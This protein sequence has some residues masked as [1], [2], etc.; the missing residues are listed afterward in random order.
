[1]QKDL[2]HYW[3]PRCRVHIF[4]RCPLLCLANAYS[5]IHFGRFLVIAVEREPFGIG[6]W[7]FPKYDMKIWWWMW[8]CIK[9]V[10][11]ILKIEGLGVIIR[12]V[13][14]GHK[15]RQCQTVARR[16]WMGIVWF[17][18]MESHNELSLPTL[19]LANRSQLFL[20]FVYNQCKLLSPR[21]VK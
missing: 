17:C 2:K 15:S 21:P 16:Y 8:L 3:S 18:A 11:Y 10:L 13:T 7:N 14:L 12:Y 1:M 5:H 6:F 4:A 20:L 9:I 19:Q